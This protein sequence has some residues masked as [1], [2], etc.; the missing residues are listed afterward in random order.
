[1]EKLFDIVSK[2]STPLA[3]S[4]VI[5]AIF[6]LIARE[7]IR[8]NIF[9]ELTKSLA[10]DTIKLIVDKLFLLAMVAI[11]LGFVGYAM[12][13][14]MANAFPKLAHQPGQSPND[15]PADLHISGLVRDDDSGQAISGAMILVVEKNRTIK[16]NDQGQFDLQVDGKEHEPVKLIVSKPGYKTRE[17][18]DFLGN[19]SVNIRLE[20]E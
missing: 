11:V 18:Q 19:K 5:A 8:K 20:R 12:R 9:P 10:F 7:I 15:K 2:I 13:L 4:G 1:M 14:Y 3:L 6:F 16:S 17:Q